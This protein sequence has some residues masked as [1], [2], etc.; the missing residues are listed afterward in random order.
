MICANNMNISTPLLFSDFLVIG[1]AQT[2]LAFKPSKIALHIALRSYCLVHYR[3]PYDI[4][5]K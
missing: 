5:V 2:S 1:L 3:K 4:W